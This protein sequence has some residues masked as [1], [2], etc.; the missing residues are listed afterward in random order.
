MQSRKNQGLFGKGLNNQLFRV[1]VGTNLS[2]VRKQEMGV[3]QG[4][5]LSV[6]LFSVKINSIIKSINPGVGC[7]LYVDDFVICFRSSHM[8]II[9]GQLQQCLNR[10]KTRSDENGFK[11]SKQNVFI[12]VI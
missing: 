4:C 1:K 2:D 11:F 9:E 5:I 3:P 8:A 6:T 7:C 10:L 12:F